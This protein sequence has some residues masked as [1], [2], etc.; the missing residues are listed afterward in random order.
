M[1]KVNTTSPFSN[2]SSTFRAIRTDAQGNIYF[3]GSIRGGSH[4]FA[5]TTLSASGT[6]N[7]IFLAKYNSQGGF[8]WVKVIGANGFDNAFDITLDNQGNVYLVGDFNANG[9]NQAVD[10]NDNLNSGQPPYNLIPDICP[11][12]FCASGF[13]AKYTS[14]GAIIWAVKTAPVPPSTAGS[15][16]L[17]G[18]AVDNIGSVFVAGGTTGIVERYNANTG[19]RIWRR[20][21]PEGSYATSVDVHNGGLYICGESDNSKAFVA[22]LQ[23]GGGVPVWQRIITDEIEIATKVRINKNTGNVYVM[24]NGRLASYTPAGVN[25]WDGIRTFQRCDTRDFWIANNGN[26]YLTGKYN[27]SDSANFGNGIILQGVGDWFLS[28]SFITKL[29]VEGI[30]QYAFRIDNLGEGIVEGGAIHIDGN[31]KIILG[32]NFGNKAQFNVCNTSDIANV[33]FPNNQDVFIAKYTETENNISISGPNSFCTSGTYII[34]GLPVGAVVNWSVG[35]NLNIINQ[36]NLMVTVSSPAT[37][38]SNSFIQ[39]N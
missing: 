34:N 30:A 35:A 27:R 1:Q 13:L 39:A 12:T 21:L 15:P 18:V 7:N 23:V 16:S 29:D 19:E 37:A 11:N 20:V 10:F 8:I 5:G 6:E 31:G 3:A 28:N 4:N 38:I 33:T 36:T 22:R 14:D 25:R 24:M 32:G 17:Y 26:I 9:S 2:G